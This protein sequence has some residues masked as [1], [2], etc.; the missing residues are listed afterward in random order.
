MTL[1]HRIDTPADLRRLSIA[2]LPQVSDELRQFILE[3]ISRIG[4]HLGAALGVVEL[5]VALHYVF[6]SPTDRIIWDVGHQAH[7]H[8]ILTGRRD[9]FHTVKQEGGL[10]G[11]LKRSESPH[12]IFG[13]GHASTSISA[14]LGV[15][16]ALRLKAERGKTVAVIGDGGLTG[17]MAFEALNA[18]GALG[19]ELIIVVNDNGMSISP[20]VGALSEWF[21][22]KLVGQ[23]MTRWRR[24][25]RSFLEAFEG[26]GD[27]AIR[28][29]EHM[30][31][32]SKALMLT[33][34]L[35][36]EGLGF[37]YL[38]P[39]DGHDLSGMV[40]AFRDARQVGKPVVVHTCT[41]KGKGA[42]GV[43]ED[44]ERKHAVT[45]FDL[46][47]GKSLKTSKPSPPTYTEVFGRTL[48]ELA[49][50]DPRVV[51]ITAAMSDG[52]GLNAFAE[53][54]PS[55]FY[56][57]GIAEQ[58]AVTFAAGLAV[59]GF[60]P[61]AA[62]YST[63]LQRAF[64]QILHDVCLQN[65]PVIFCMDRAGLVGADG[66]THHGVFDIGYMRM[67]PNLALLAPRDEDMLRHM[68]ET[69][70]RCGRPVGIRYPR[71]AGRGVDIEGP[72]R[73]IPWGR[74]EVL[75]EAGEGSPLLLAAGPLAHDALDA[76][77][78]LAREG[79]EVTVIDPRFLKPLDEEL[80][81]PRLA[82]APWTLTLEE[83][84]LAGGFGTAI[85][86]LCEAHELRPLVKRLGIGDH[87]VGHGDPG[88][89]RERSGLDMA[90]IA[91]TALRLARPSEANPND[92]VTRLRRA[93]PYD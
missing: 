50:T 59:E 74:G 83:N 10:S 33:P 88:R 71:G 68:L 90:S 38:G 2:E 41:T 92:D 34:G 70:R 75:R 87:F 31:D 23:P 63:F 60:R 17:G 21:S 52:T 48:C 9:L 7:G 18:A 85:L 30:M 65:L 81:L 1:L 53:R 66:P 35:L 73:E 4:G 39:I 47:S 40:N 79:V 54:F 93:G 61:V 11:F 72:L 12:D 62:I 20:N 51:A 27:D 26:V 49:A 32:A 5:T 37:E 44:R 77:E 89:L 28:F 86:E 29:I 19:H 57:V 58:H 14:A 55:R 78:R 36:F 46:R 25:V 64:D 24:R 22:R 67:I 42:P 8:K 76:A 15:R 84:V 45:P 80:L 16:E 13:A 91:A 43:D 82:A 69:A 56:D 6:E 3:K